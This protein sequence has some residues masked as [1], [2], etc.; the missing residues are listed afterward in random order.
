MLVAK[1]DEARVAEAEAILQQANR[2]DLTE[3]RTAYRDDGWSRFD[4]NSSPYTSD[5]FDSTRL[6]RGI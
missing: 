4:E 3:R 1:V 6:R 2:V 5:E